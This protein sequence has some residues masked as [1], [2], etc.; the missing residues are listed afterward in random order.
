[1]AKRLIDWTV[2]K[3]GVLS[4]NKY[5]DDKDAPV[6]TLATFDTKE[7]PENI[8]DMALFY[9]MKQKLS[10]SG[11]SDVGDV[12]AKVDSAK[13]K[14]DDLK[15]GRWVGIRVNATGSAENK[16]IAANV[17]TLSKVVSLDGLMMKKLNFPESFTD[18]DQKKLDEFMAMKVKAGTK[19]TK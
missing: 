3:E 8:R 19:K 12:E 14:F 11:A 10:D 6:E 17:K 9:G 5:N 4:M 15:N 2:D 7:L 18:E 13:A 16:R 1:M